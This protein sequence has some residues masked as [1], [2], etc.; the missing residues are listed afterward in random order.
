MGSVPGLK[1]SPRSKTATP[2]RYSL[3]RTVR[4]RS[5][6]STA[7]CRKRQSSLERERIGFLRMRCSCCW[8][9]SAVGAGRGCPGATVSRGYVGVSVARL[10]ITILPLRFSAC[11][12]GLA[13]PLGKILFLVPAQEDIHQARV[14]LP[15]A[16]P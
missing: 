8:T 6:C 4:L 2:I 7:N 14:K 12:D 13:H 10:A 15:A 1:V 9:A 16:L 11:Q 5:F 3:R